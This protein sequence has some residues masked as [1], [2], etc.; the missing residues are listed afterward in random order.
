MA[1]PH[2]PIT[3]ETLLH[4]MARTMG[5]ATDRLGRTRTL[6]DLELSTHDFM[7]L[8]AVLEDRCD[9]VLPDCDLARCE[10]TGDLIE[11]LR[12]LLAPRVAPTLNDRAHQAAKAGGHGH[13]QRA[14]EG[15]P[16]RGAPRRSPAGLHASHAQE[17]QAG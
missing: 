5:L 11:R 2:K 1:A 4:L 3:E 14:P 8:V 13:G 6:E 9:V 12:G 7:A 15:D 16:R 10:T 17:R